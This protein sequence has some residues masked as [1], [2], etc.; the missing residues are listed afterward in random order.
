MGLG[1][2]LF[3][4]L[5]GLLLVSISPLKSWRL[6]TNAPLDD[7]DLKWPT[8]GYGS[9]AISLDALFSAHAATLLLIGYGCFAG[10]VS[11]VVAGLVL[12]NLWLSRQP[13]TAGFQSLLYNIRVFESA[14]ADQLFWL[15]IVTCQLGLAVSEL[16]LLHHI[17]AVGLGFPAAHAFT[18][19][20]SIA[21]VAYYYCLIGGYAAVFKTDALQYVFVLVMAAVMFILAW[22]AEPITGLSTVRQPPSYEVDLPLFLRDSVLLKRSLE[23]LAGFALGIMPVIVAPDAWKRV[24]IISRNNMRKKPL[25]RR[26]FTGRHAAPARLLFVTALPVALTTPLIWRSSGGGTNNSVSYP[27]QA[28]FE[29]CPPTAE[30]FLVLGMTAAFMSTFDSGH[31]SA[32]HLLLKE[33]HL[34]AGIAQSELGRFRVIFGVCFAIIILLFFAI[35]EEAPHPYVVGAFLIG[36]YAIA[37]GILTGTFFGDRLLRGEFI[38]YLVVLALAIWIFIFLHHISDTESGS[39]PYSAAP[40]V[41]AGCTFYFLFTGAAR[42]LSRKTLLGDQGA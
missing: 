34:S 7:D 14:P 13:S 35:A 25:A 26:S 8:A 36:P 12:L 33:R 42:L 11:G 16:V 18:A 32:S 10:V 41:A 20:L 31:L 5:L 22:T 23:F 40:L 2:A 19:S 17:F 3:T 24:L 4:F 28:I 30:V 6:D 29:A 1:L 38:H 21:F 39:N 9:A 37:G 27:L 15:L